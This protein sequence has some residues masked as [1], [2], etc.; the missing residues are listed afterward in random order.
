MG[1]AAPYRLPRSRGA[2][3]IPG[4]VR[5]PANPRYHDERSR[6]QSLA[7]G[8][9][10]EWGADDPLEAGIHRYPREPGDFLEKDHLR[11]SCRDGKTLTVEGSEHRDAH[12]RHV[13][14]PGP[15][16]R[17]P[18]VALR[19]ARV[20]TPPP[21]AWTGA[22]ATPSSAAASTAPATVFGIS[23]HLRSRNTRIPR[24]TRSRISAGPSRV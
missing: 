3:L 11:P 12:Q 19:A 13:A 16:R 6:P 20:I 9:Y 17:S 10:F 15:R 24:R 21:I 23:C 7:R 8:F 14:A 22:I 4:R 18:P 2:R 5:R 1:G